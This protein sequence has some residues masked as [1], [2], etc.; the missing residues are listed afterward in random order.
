MLFL[1]TDETTASTFQPSRPANGDA[2]R[3]QL[4]SL[5]N[6]KTP[7]GTS[8]IIGLMETLINKTTDVLKI[9]ELNTLTQLSNNNTALRALAPPTL[10]NSSKP[11]LSFEIKNTFVNHYDSNINTATSYDFIDISNNATEMGLKNVSE[12]K[13]VTRIEQENQSFVSQSRRKLNL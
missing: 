8:A 10:M 6:P 5:I 2:L 13:F 11:T 3:N 12:E 7:N 4:L 9:R 1:F